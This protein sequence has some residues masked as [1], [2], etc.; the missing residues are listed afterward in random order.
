MARADSSWPG[1]SS[2]TS[3]PSVRMAT[4]AWARSFTG[5]A[6]V[7]LSKRGRGTSV[8]SRSPPRRART[9]STARS[10]AVLSAMRGSRGAR[11]TRPSALVRTSPASSLA[12]AADS[13]SSAAPMKRAASPLATTG[14]PPASSMPGLS[15]CMA[16]TALSPAA[17]AA[18]ATRAQARPYRP[19][20]NAGPHTTRS[21][22]ASWIS[23]TISAMASGRPAASSSP[24]ETVATISWSSPRSWASLRPGPTGPGCEAGGDDAASSPPAPMK[25]WLR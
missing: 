21:G 23:A 12:T 8:A 1:L 2:G 22:D 18:P 17:L 25:N 6:G 19:L 3:P 11:P 14:A 9:R 4:V 13:V 10:A 16:A 7:T 20:V 24:Q 15:G 5:G